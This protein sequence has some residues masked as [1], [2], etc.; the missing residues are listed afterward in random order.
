MTGA[1]DIALAHRLMG[2]EDAPAVVLLGTLGTDAALWQ[3]LLPHLPG[4][5]RY[6]SVDLRGHGASPC[7]PGPYRMGALVGDV[8][9]LLDG[10]GLRDTL[11]VGCGL[12]GMI[13]Q[14]LA[15]KRLDLVRGLVLINSAARLGQAAPWQDRAT[16]IRAAGMGAFAEEMLPLWQARN[17]EAQTADPAALLARQSPEGVAATCEAIAGTDFYTPTSGLRLA[18]LGLAGIDDRFCPPDLTR[19]TVGLIPGAKFEILRRAGHLPML[20]APETLGARLAAFFDG[21]GHPAPTSQ[22]RH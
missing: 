10:L 3:P 20:D 18:C 21:I 16:R 17:P 11:L 2:P 5:L 13:A 1:Q 7:P 8:E 12:G 6:L 22:H 15:V 19:E 14:G 4:T 9:R